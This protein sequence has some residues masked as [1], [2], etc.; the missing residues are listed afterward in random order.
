MRREREREREETGK[1][2]RAIMS[3]FD[4]FTEKLSEKVLIAQSRVAEAVDAIR[5]YLSLSL[6]FSLLHTLTLSLS[7]SQLCFDDF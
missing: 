6:S 4:V 7:L 3:N 1:R 5:E 2:E